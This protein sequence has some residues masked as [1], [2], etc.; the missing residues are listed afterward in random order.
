MGLREFGWWCEFL[1]DKGVK[2]VSKD[3]WNLVR[4]H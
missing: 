4:L 2:G 3:V 1:E